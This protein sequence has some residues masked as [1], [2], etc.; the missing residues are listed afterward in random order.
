MGQK[1][2]FANF[3]NHGVAFD[4]AKIV[5]YDEHTVNLETAYL[6]ELVDIL[7]NLNK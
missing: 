5:F 2:D 1:K 6:Q 7:Y 4:E 3:R